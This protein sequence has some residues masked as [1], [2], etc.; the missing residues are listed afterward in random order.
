[1]DKKNQKQEPG[2]LQAPPVLQPQI[3]L[4]R[5]TITLNLLKPIPI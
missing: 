3:L 1:M 4:K 2:G 5:Q